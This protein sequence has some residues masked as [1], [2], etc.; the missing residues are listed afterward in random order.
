MCVA[1]AQDLDKQ[2]FMN[3]KLFRVQGS[4]RRGLNTYQLTS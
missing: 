3:I 2:G 4:G 1:V